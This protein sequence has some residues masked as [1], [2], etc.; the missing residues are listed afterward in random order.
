MFRFL[1][2]CLF[3]TT[4]ARWGYNEIAMV[5][6]SAVPLIDKAIETIEIPT[7]DTWSRAAL[8]NYVQDARYALIE[9]RDTIHDI[10][11]AIREAK[12]G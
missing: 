5:F 8:N 11:D 7:H 9:A 4:V 2:A 6:P 12:R 1:I 10:K 3:Y